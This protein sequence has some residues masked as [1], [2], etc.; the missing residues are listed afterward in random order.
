MKFE[1]LILHSLFL[2]LF[3]HNFVN[4][5]M[6]LIVDEQIEVCTKSGIE[7]ALDFSGF[8][9]IAQTDTTIFGNGTVKFLK[10]A[11]KPLKAHVFAE[12][13]ERGKWTPQVFDKKF[14]DFCA[15]KDNPKSYKY[16]VDCP[17]CPFQAGASLKCFITLLLSY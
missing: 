9:L 11:A 12:K 16:F 10:N 5:Q 1:S 17:P 14:H 3:L 2:G 7:R 8:E 15:E 6:E 4:G 13:F